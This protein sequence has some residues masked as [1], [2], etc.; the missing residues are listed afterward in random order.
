MYSPLPFLLLISHGEVQHVLKDWTV[1]FQI[2]L[3][4]WNNELK[5]GKCLDATMAVLLFS[6]VKAL[7][8]SVGKG[9][10]MDT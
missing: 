7:S 10:K 5:T 3:F 2:E 8:P 4:P 6:H 9:N 1:N